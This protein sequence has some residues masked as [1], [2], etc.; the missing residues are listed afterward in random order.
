MVVRALSS[1]VDTSVRRWAA[2]RVRD[3]AARCTAHSR[4]SEARVGR[5][6][7]GFL[8]RARSVL[9]KR[10][11]GSRNALRDDHPPRVEH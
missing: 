5:R 10:S 11:V 4:W 1:G 7:R 3:R 2:E 6:R 8:R 9:W